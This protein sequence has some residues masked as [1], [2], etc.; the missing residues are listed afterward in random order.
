LDITD[1]VLPK[2][3]RLISS[4][5][6]HFALLGGLVVW[7]FGIDPG[8]ENS[9]GDLRST[10][11]LSQVQ[12][13]YAQITM[14][15]GRPLT[16]G[17]KSDAIEV[18]L[19]REALFLYSREIA[20]FVSENPEETITAKTRVREAVELGLIESDSITRRI[21][22]D[23]ARRLIRATALVQVPTTEGLQR[24]LEENPSRYQIPGRTRITHVALNRNLRKEKTI[25]A[26]IVMLSKLTAGGLSPEE[27]AALGDETVV[28]PSLPD[29]TDRAIARRFG[30][31]F[32]E[33]LV[34]LPVGEWQGPI[35]SPLGEHIVFVHE[36]RPPRR[37][38]LGEVKEQVSSDIRNELADQVL[39]ARVKE[40]REQYGLKVDEVSL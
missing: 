22:I 11:S 23:G 24:Y 8:A 30:V 25:D 14:E 2:F 33:V 18:M 20:T 36:R 37:A 21:L 6:V 34:D 1:L 39:I 13:V 17:E 40:L 4:P 27:G 32:T 16:D 19:N 28:D 5:A 10:I 3:K 26:A 31:S 29:M 7:L 9:P 35:R 12:R 38:M 15:K